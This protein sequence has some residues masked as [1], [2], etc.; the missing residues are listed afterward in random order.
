MDEIYI[1]EQIEKTALALGADIVGFSCVK[2]IKE[3]YLAGFP[4][5]VIAGVKLAD[6]VVNEIDKSPS[7]TYFKLYRTVNTLLDDIALRLGN[8]IESHGYS[9]FMVP[10]SQTVPDNSAEGNK[11]GGY[12]G[13]FSHKTAAVLAGLG[14]IGKSGLFVNDRFGPRVRLVTVLTNFRFENGYCRDEAV[15]EAERKCRHICGNCRICVDSCPAMA[16]TGNMPKIG[17]KRECLV[18]ARAC[19]EY[20]SKHFKEI[21]R[22]SVCGI[23]M[24]VCPASSNY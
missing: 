22:G 19:S 18:D 13:I 23:C 11:N 14:H 10:A 9:A 12:A 15:E 16:I 7:F 21:G 3:G 6:G 2:G 1:Q 4:Y 24:K 5:A 17:N 8:L 20:M